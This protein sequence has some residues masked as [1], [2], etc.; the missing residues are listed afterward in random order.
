MKYVD[1]KKFKK[2]VK[3]FNMKRMLIFIVMPILL[4]IVVIIMALH[5]MAGGAYSEGLINT[6]FKVANWPS[7][8]IKLSP[9]DRPDY[10]LLDCIT[11]KILIVNIIGWSIIGILVNIYFRK[12][13][14]ENL[15]KEHKE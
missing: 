12:N 1:M 15:L 3:N 4:D 5:G 10:A 14:R 2:P 7:I 11:P 6:L 13:Q 9:F 8:L